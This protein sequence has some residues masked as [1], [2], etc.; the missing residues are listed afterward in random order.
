MISGKSWLSPSSLMYPG[1][2]DSVGGNVG[3][4]SMVGGTDPSDVVSD[5]PSVVMSAREPRSSADPGSDPDPP[6]PPLLLLLLLLPRGT[7]MAGRA[8]N[9][10]NNHDYNCMKKVSLLA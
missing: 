7:N 8:G 1:G 3:C 2:G 5:T 9:R 6:T 10:H 4:G